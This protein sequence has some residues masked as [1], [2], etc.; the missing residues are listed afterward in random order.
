M[1]RFQPYQ[2]EETIT[3]TITKREAILIEKLREYSFGQLTVFKANGLI[4]RIEPKESIII[5]EKQKLTILEK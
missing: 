4:I 1:T 2:P 3:C 5:D